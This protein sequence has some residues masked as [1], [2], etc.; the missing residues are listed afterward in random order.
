MKWM[1][2][3]FLLLVMAN[4]GFYAWFHYLRT[5][6]NTTASIEQ[7]Q[8]APEKIR[9]VNSPGAAAATKAALTGV[10]C[11][12]WSAFAGAA[13]ARADA[14]IAELGLSAAQVQR[15]TADASGFWVYIPPAKTR[16]EADKAA[17]Q[18][19]TLDIT[20][21]TVVQDKTA[22]RN[23][24]SLGL[25]RTEDAA[26]AYLA[27]V[28]KK[29]VSNAAVER[30][31]NLL[32]QVIYYVREPSEATV[33]KLMAMRVQLPASDIKAVSCPTP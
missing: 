13:V 24:I 16:A 29:G 14:A 6:L 27:E 7:V 22:W 32:K 1:R 20:D 15:V 11:L 8:I 9:V 26:N 18:L 28:Q 30:R 19:K 5:P 25:F 17:D 3:L 10:A 2:A 21:Y 23:A 4:L 31:E 12:E 33:A